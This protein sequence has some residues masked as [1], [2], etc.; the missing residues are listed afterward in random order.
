M[1]KLPKLGDDLIS[2]VYGPHE[3]RL[4]APCFQDLKLRQENCAERADQKD[5]PPTRLQNRSSESIAWQTA[6]IRAKYRHRSGKKQKKISRTLFPSHAPARCR[7]DLHSSRILIHMGPNFQAS[8]EVSP[9]SN[10][11]C[12]K[13]F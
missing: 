6:H 7:F 10:V 12:R 5:S 1:S 13:S 3:V 4:N 2:F 11:T 8:R 9:Q